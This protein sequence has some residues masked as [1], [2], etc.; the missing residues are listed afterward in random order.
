MQNRKFARI[1]KSEDFLWPWSASEGLLIVAGASGGGGG[2][3]GAFCLEGLNLYGA[4]GGQ[5]GNGGGLTR[6]KR[7]NLN[8]SASGGNGGDGG[9]AGCLQDGKPVIGAK[10]KGSHYGGG[11]DGGSGANPPQ[12][13]GRV[14]SNGG[15]GGKGFPGEI[16]IYELTELSIGER[17]E[18]IVGNGGNGGSGGLGYRI[19]GEGGRGL[20][21]YVILVPFSVDTKVT[22]DD[23]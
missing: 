14:L 7:S 17:F 23:S 20:S 1:E 11:G 13:D 9:S 19:G 10:G 18:I 15:E 8:F 12:V 22:L 2:G 3:G 21:G 4:T 16:Q 5:G 6:V